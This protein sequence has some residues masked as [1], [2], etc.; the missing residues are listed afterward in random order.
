[1]ARYL[2]F[3]DKVRCLAA[4]LLLRYLFKDSAEL[5]CTNEYGKPYLPDSPIRFNLS[6]SGVFVVLAADGDELGVD[7]EQIKEHRRFV[8]ERY[9]TENELR[10]LDSQSDT[11]LAFCT[12]WA[13]KESV[14]KATGLG[15]SLSPKSFSLIPWENSVITPGGTSWHLNRYPIEG[16]ALCVSSKN[17]V[18]TRPVIL[19]REQLLI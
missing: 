11:A 10:W 1:M 15:F 13:G 18:R 19:H 2:R 12:L 5:I 3:E 4:G 7:I 6:H 17:N 9:Y 16:Y 8:A 14:L